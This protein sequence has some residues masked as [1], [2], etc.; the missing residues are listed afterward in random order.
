MEAGTEQ[1]TG[2]LLTFVLYF[3]QQARSYQTGDEGWGLW[4]ESQY[5]KK[6]RS[7]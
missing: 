5:L 4:A 6:V 1:F 7:I 2:C 3:I